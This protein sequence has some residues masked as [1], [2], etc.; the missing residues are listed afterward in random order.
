MLA[1]VS[2]S[3]EG[4]S[5]YRYRCVW[6]W[7]TFH[8]DRQNVRLVG[9]VRCTN[10]CVRLHL[11]LLL[12]GLLLL[13]LDRALVL[14]HHALRPHPDGETLLEAALLALP[15]HVHVHLAR[16]PKLAAVHRI[17]GY[18][19][20]K[21]TY[22]INKVVSGVRCHIRTPYLPLHPSQVSAL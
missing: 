19:A 8:Q 16:V 1:L 4:A 20:P 18:A 10:G 22:K 3:Q 7:I 2:H 14:G 12:L 6:R 5:S 11:V 13:P 21:E 17:L 9:V 15:P